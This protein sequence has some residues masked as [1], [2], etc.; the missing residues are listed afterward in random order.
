MSLKFYYNSLIP[1]SA[2]FERIMHSLIIAEFTG[3]HLLKYFVE[4]G[5]EP[6]ALR[7]ES[8]SESTVILHLRFLL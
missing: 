1:S 3:H 4:D 2:V 8:P 6:E 7:L 5:S